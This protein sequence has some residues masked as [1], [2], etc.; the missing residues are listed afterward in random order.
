[1]TS[2]SANEV[3]QIPASPSI[4]ER[5]EMLRKKGASGLGSLADDILPHHF[6]LQ[7]LRSSQDHDVEHE[8]MDTNCDHLLG[9][10]EKSANSRS[11]VESVQHS[12]PPDTGV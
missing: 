9:A 5:C 6:P 4:T 1:M 12:G 11:S 7:S 2:A 8:V 10:R 3:F